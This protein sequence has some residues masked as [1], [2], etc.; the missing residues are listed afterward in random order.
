VE[1]Q[2]TRLTPSGGAALSVCPP[3]VVVAAAAAA[4]AAAAKLGA[5][6]TPDG[7]DA[8]TAPDEGRR[9]ELPSGAD[10]EADDRAADEVAADGDVET[11]HQVRAIGRHHCYSHRRLGWSDLRL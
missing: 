2:S 9:R 10:S 4:A 3:V 11:T 6:Q 7:L 1:R 8:W 5:A